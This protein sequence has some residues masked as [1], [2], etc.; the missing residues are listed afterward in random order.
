MA[1]EPDCEKTNW[2]AVALI[3]NRLPSTKGCLN[4]MQTAGV[5]AKLKC[6]RLSRTGVKDNDR[7]AQEMNNQ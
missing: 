3:L 7:T 5:K 1:L 6:G 4:K 2:R